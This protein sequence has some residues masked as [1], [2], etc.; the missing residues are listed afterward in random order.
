M[1][2]QA[3]DDVLVLLP[4]I[5]LFRIATRAVSPHGRDLLAGVLLAVTTAAMLMPA[6]FSPAGSPWHPLFA[7]VHAVVWLA[8][9]V[10]L[11]QQAPLQLKTEKVLET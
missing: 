11:L 8:V 6:R 2:H 4:M 10:F 7:G 5:A 1:Y 9:L 3:C